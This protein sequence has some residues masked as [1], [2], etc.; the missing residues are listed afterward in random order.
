[1]VRVA[2]ERFAPP[3][4]SFCVRMDSPSRLVDVDS[5]VFVVVDALFDVLAIVN[6]PLQ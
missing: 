1:M 4:R 5:L 2:V 3:L 6:H